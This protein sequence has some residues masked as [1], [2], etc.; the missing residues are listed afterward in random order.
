MA[1]VLEHRWIII[2]SVKRLM[3]L[4]L[5]LALVGLWLIC[6]TLPAAASPSS[7]VVYF[8]PTPRPDGRIIYIV[9]QPDTCISVSLL[10]RISEEQLRTLNNIR[11]L[12]CVI[13]V[14]QEL[15]I[16]YAGPA[17]SPTPGP[18]PTPTPLLPTSTPLPGK[19]AVCIV[20]FE[21]VNGN[22]LLEDTEALMVGGAVSV[23]D[24]S[25]KFSQTGT[26]TGDPTKP[27]CFEN[28]VEGDYN[29]SLAVP[30]GCNPTT[31][32]SS[33]IKLQAGDT[34]I[35]DFGAQVSLKAPP[36]AATPESG[37]RIPLFGLLGAGLILAGI[38]LGFYLRR[39][40]K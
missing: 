26:T 1:M 21:D 12:K 33:S 11:G 2:N 15:L 6:Q 20:L 19:G 7:Q 8:T 37:S 36:P 31:F 4:F 32:T 5:G 28:L 13:Q 22:G 38:G 9:K 27:L 10:H 3:I 35:L 39:I 34:S 24:R 23:T 40:M 30:Q 18:S 29:I 17:E 14:G 25:G 16:G